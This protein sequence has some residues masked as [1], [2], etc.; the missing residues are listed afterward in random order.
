MIL[1]SGKNTNLH[2]KIIL[3]NFDEASKEWRKNKVSLKLGMFK[4]K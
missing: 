1:R 2:S 3:I 4:Y